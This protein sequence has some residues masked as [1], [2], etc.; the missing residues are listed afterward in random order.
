MQ[1]PTT[2]TISQ[3][4]NAVTGI[5]GQIIEVT[6][7]TNGPNTFKH[8]CKSNFQEK[9]ITTFLLGDNYILETLP[10]INL[11]CAALPPCRALMEGVG[12]ALKPE[13]TA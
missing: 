6:T 1:S 13:T 11:R 9:E 2:P 5:S 3:E 8:Y 10:T 12:A 4:W 7:T